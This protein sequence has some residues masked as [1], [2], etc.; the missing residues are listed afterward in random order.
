[1]FQWM[2]RLPLELCPAQ[3]FDHPIDGAWV[4]CS[5]RHSLIIHRFLALKNDVHVHDAR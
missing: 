4:P 5:L 2:K 1:M 3:Y